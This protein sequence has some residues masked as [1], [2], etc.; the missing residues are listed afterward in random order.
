MLL[1]SYS[2]ILA[3]RVLM[4]LTYLPKFINS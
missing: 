2:A 3:A 4:N 1:F